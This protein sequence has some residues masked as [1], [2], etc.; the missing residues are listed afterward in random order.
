MCYPTPNSW[1]VSCLPGK[2]FVMAYESITNDDEVETWWLD[3]CDSTEVEMIKDISEEEKIQILQFQYDH[4]ISDLPR[5]L[6]DLYLNNA[7]EKPP[8]DRYMGDAYV[9]LQSGWYEAHP[10]D[11]DDQEEEYRFLIAMRESD[12]LSFHY[13][14]FVGIESSLYPNTFLEIESVGSPYLRQQYES[15]HLG[16]IFT[17][18][19]LT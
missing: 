11:Q 13:C 3:Y 14:I 1:E 19:L 5:M 10:G 18:C 2:D 17:N 9:L 8:Y 4:S 12:N 7:W 16:E 6:N 15:L